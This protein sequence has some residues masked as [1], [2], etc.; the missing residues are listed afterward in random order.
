MNNQQKEDL[1]LDIEP[2]DLQPLSEKTRIDLAHGILQRWKAGRGEI[3]FEG[4]P[5]DHFSEEE[6]RKIVEIAMDQCER[7]T[8]FYKNSVAGFKTIAKGWQRAAMREP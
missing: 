2:L 7:E 5:L 3:Q 4:V 6:L 8:K 1:G